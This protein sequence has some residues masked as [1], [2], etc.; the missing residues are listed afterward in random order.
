MITTLDSFSGM[1]FIFISL[2][3]SL[4]LPFEAYSSVSSFCLTC[5]V[6]FY[7]LGGAAN[8]PEFEGMILCLVIPYVDY[9]P[10]DFC[11]LASWTCGWHGLGEPGTFHI[12]SPLSGQ[13][14]LKQIQVRMSQGSV[15]GE[16]TSRTAEA[17]MG[18][19]QSVPG[20]SVQGVPWQNGWS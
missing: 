6:Y 5:C 20:C 18:A 3:P 19:S 7:G 14:K 15:C 11:W 4:V 9:M 8:S 16:H 17:E 10:G 1:L 12:M 13:L 2:G